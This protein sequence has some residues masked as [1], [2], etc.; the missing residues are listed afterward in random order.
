MSDDLPRLPQRPADAHKGDFGR[1]L[2]IG[3]SQGMSGAI[4]LAALAALRGGSGLVTVA[5]PAGIQ[6]VVARQEPSYMTAGLPQDGEGQFASGA[7]AAIDDQL[8]TYDA[9]GCGPGMGQS[10]AAGELARQL[11]NSLGAPLV[12]DADALNVLAGEFSRLQPAGARILT[13]HPGEFRRLA[14]RD[15]DDRAASEQAARQWAADH[16][17]VLVLKGQRTLITDGESSFNNQTG[18]PGMA[19]GGCGDVLTGLI[20]AL[21]GQGLAPLAAARLGVYLHG[22]AGDLAAEAV[23]EVSL[24]ASDLLEQLPRAIQQH[25]C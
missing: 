13:P 21:L 2:L 9:V 19:T 5:V 18:N 8:S 15:F 3:G 1:V 23:G 4:T 22:L 16:R 20:V 11:Y 12:M 24:I 10:A 6:Q 7:L 25:G 14:G 17:L